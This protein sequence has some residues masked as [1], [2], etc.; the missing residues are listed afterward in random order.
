M[1][2]FQIWYDQGM[3]HLWNLTDYGSCQ[4]PRSR[5]IGERPEHGAQ[6]LRFCQESPKKGDINYGMITHGRDIVINMD[7]HDAIAR[8]CYCHHE[9]LSMHLAEGLDGRRLME[10]LSAKD[11]VLTLTGV[12][13]GSGV[14]HQGF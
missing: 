9:V 5:C 14:L 8:S 7:I 13:P 2:N 6:N 4:Y 12:L 3:L 1:K 10:H 11:A